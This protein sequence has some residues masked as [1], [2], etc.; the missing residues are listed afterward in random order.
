MKPQFFSLIFLICFLP[1]PS[2]VP[3]GWLQELS[4]RDDLTLVYHHDVSSASTTMQIFL[5]G[6]RALEPPQKAGVAYLMH[7]LMLVI[8]DPQKQKQVVQWGGRLEFQVREDFSVLSLTCLSE[9]FAPTLR[10]LA[11]TLAAPPLSGNPVFR[12]K[13]AM[14]YLQKREEDDDQ[15]FLQLA[16]RKVFFAHSGL[17]AS[18]YGDETTRNKIKSRD[19]RHYYQTTFVAANMTIAVSSDLDKETISDILARYFPV[20]STGKPVGRSTFLPTTPKERSQHFSRQ[21]RQVL[22][23]MA[24]TTPPLSPRSLIGGLLLENLLG[25]GPG[26]R[27]WS[28]REK[29]NLAYLV[30]A[31]IQQHLPGLGGKIL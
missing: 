12:A 17:A 21:R 16:L 30:A 14:V 25:G 8:Q 31:R 5:K 2:L 15:R 3:A 9:H 26:S 6:G 18:T 28:L 1:P 24:A 10:I 27:L 4:P 29:K 22:L 23:V 19:V 13:K 7:R 20:F 11:D